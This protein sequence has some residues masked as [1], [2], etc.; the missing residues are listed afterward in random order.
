M[1]ARDALDTNTPEEQA[2]TTLA[3]SRTAP[4]GTRRTPVL[5]I[6]LVAIAVSTLGLAIRLWMTYLPDRSD[7]AA[8][9][10]RGVGQA[11]ATVRREA[12]DLP[13]LQERV[14]R[15][16]QAVLPSVVSVRNPFSRASGTTGHQEGTASGVIITADGLVLSQ[17]HVSHEKSFEDGHRALDPASWP[18]GLAGEKTTVILHDGR[19]CPAELLGANRDY[20]LSLLRLLEP[21][22]YPHVP[23]R[24]TAPVEAGDWALQIGHPLGYRRDRSAPVRLGRIVGGTGEAFATDCMGG[25]GDSGG[26]FF[27]LD[28]QLLGI[29]NARLGG[30][31]SARQHD[32]DF[33]RLGGPGLWQVAGS[34]LID[35]LMDAMLQGEVSPGDRKG[36][37]QIHDKILASARLQTADYSQ[38]SA[39]LARYRSIVGPTRPS[40][41]VVL[42]E[43]VAIS[44]GTV[45]A[46]DG[47]VVTKASELP[48]RPTCRLPDGK[49]VSARVVGVVPAFD[50]A[51]LSLPATGLEPVQWAI[52][53]DPPVGT[54]LAAVGTEQP[55]AVGVVSVP[56]RDL[57]APV[58][59]TETL[60]LRI[61]AG[62]P[63]LSGISR[64]IGGY[65]LRAA[66]GLPRATIYRVT[67]ASGLAYSAG[68]K[69][70]DLLQSIDGRSIQAEADI[71]EAVKHRRAGDAVPVRLERGGM[72]ME[73]SLPLSPETPR[74]ETN[75]RADDFPTV[76][77]CA[78]PFFTYECGGP[79][80]DLTGRAIGITIARPGPHGGMVIPGDC[81][82]KMLPDLQDGKLAGNWKAGGSQSQ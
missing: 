6:G 7:D 80:V 47:W 60:P 66:F 16:A 35:A 76:I 38:G 1:A 19:E 57:P 45:V 75:Y 14:R 32:P 53:F 44:L 25:G 28:G 29:A 58:Y 65:S 3:R 82:M 8:G 31:T 56:R 42:N 70:Y 55:L 9:Y 39:T 61:P 5:W 43:G 74:G 71:L 77:E 63:H 48:R 50:L 33:E 21:G 20:D 72:M 79:I 27:S 46:A 52:Y 26:P 11:V 23:V 36:F 64:P 73:M 34:K 13:Q 40:V 41:V 54:L 30:L 68:I 12:G 37:G 15:T 17:W 78:V 10:G 2:P 59:P 18:T 67:G 51:L 81:I 4:A 49:V 24:A 62:R 69:P 22:P